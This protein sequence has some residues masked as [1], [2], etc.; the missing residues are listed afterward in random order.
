MHRDM[1]YCHKAADRSGIKLDERS[2]IQADMKRSPT[3][4]FA[5]AAAGIPQ[6]QFAALCWRMRRDKP[7]VLLITSRDTG[8]WVIPKGWQV[9][10]LDGAASA[11]QEAWEEAGVTGTISQQPLGRYGYDKVL[12]G[13][14]SL[15]CAVSVYPLRVMALA[16]KFPERSQR[17]RKWFTA[18]KAAR[19]VAEPDL[20]TLLQNVA[21]GTVV[22][23]A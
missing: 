6:P 8:R 22:L 12:T 20:R 11:A 15:P 18:E 1:P 7:E 5:S 4:Q 10:S 19:K 14:M 3:S 2:R 21:S 13:A 17:R 16:R 23:M 9:A